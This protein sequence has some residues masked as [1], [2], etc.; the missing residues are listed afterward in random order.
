MPDQHAG[1][2]ELAEAR[3]FMGVVQAMP[4]RKRDIVMR[5]LEG[6]NYADI[7]RARGESRTRV[8]DIIKQAVRGLATTA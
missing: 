5:R 8:F 7:G 6:E 3:D 1:P 2:A 4:K